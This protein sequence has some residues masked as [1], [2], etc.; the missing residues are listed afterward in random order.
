MLLGFVL[1]VCLVGASYGLSQVFSGRGA[2]IHV[3]AII[4]TIMVGNV[5]FVIMPA[6]RNLVK[7]IEEGTEPDP[8]LPAKGCCVHVIITISHYLCYLL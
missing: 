1:F 6:Q 3:G 8:R 5:F 4:G 2:Y 7:A